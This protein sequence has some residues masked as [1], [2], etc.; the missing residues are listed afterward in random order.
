[1]ES[2]RRE[3]TPENEGIPRA[4]FVAGQDVILRPSGY[5]LDTA[6]RS[7][8]AGSANPLACTGFRDTQSEPIPL[9]WT[10]SASVRLTQV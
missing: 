9:T 4:F 5:E 1:M 7:D 6:V 8:V 3:K 2:P 10:D